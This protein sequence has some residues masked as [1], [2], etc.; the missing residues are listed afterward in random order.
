MTGKGKLIIILL[1]PPGAG[2]GTQAKLIENKYNIP[3]ISTGD[4]LRDAID[5]NSKLGKKADVYM[6]KGSPREISD[7]LEKIKCFISQGKLVPDNIILDLVE[8]RVTQ[9]D[10]QNGALFDGFPRNVEQA[11]MLKNMKYV[12]DSESFYAILIDI[13]DKEA[14]KRLSNRRYCPKCKSIYNLI[15]KVPKKKNDGTYFCDNCGTELIIRDDDKIETIKN[16]LE[17]YHESVKPMIDFYRKH[18][19]LYIIEDAVFQDEVFHKITKIIEE[20]SEY[21]P[22]TGQ[23]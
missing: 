18:C 17:V 20:E 11:I 23:K 19:V 14:I 1:G 12:K 3:H 9:P 22:R 5:K 2:K 15:H 8:R 6:H 7:K 13:P 10:C 21:E 16:R 4:I